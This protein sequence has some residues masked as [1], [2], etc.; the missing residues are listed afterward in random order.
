DQHR[1]QLAE[2]GKAYIPFYAAVEFHPHVTE[3]ERARY[4]SA[5]A[6]MGLLDALITSDLTLLGADRMIH[7]SGAVPTNLTTILAPTLPEGCGISEE[8]VRQVLSCISTQEAAFTWVKA[9]GSYQVGNLIGSAV[10]REQSLYIGRES[11]RQYRQRELQRLYA[12]QT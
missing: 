4:E 1:Q 7:T 10:L 3:A 9:D 6:E 12:E 2:Q 5:F 11:R 8:Q